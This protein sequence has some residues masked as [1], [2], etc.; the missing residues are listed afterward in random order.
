MGSKKTAE[1]IENTTLDDGVVDYTIDM[2]N[3][4]ITQSRNA[5]QPMLTYLL[6]MALIEAHR[7]SA[8]MPPPTHEAALSVN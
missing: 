4:L 3:T 7:L 8:D 5:Q 1:T 6:S 2:L